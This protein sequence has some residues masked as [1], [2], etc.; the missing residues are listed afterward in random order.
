M[1]NPLRMSEKPDPYPNT[2]KDSL[3]SVLRH[4]HRESILNSS[5]ALATPSPLLADRAS[6]INDCVYFFRLYF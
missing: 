6:S 3:A 4:V 1:L 5:C 2:G